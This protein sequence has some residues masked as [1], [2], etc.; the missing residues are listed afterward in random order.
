MTTEKLREDSHNSKERN[1]AIKKAAP[2][3]EKPAKKAAKKA[4]KKAN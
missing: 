3:D 1:A 4:F 2:K